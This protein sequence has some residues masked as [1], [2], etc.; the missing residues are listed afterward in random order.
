MDGLAS[1]MRQGFKKNQEEMADMVKNAFQSNQEYMDKRF[2][3]VDKKFDAVDKRFDAMDKRFDQVV[4]EIHKI[5]LN[6]VD[7]V[8]KEDFDKLEDRVVVLEERADL[9]GKKS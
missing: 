4:Q 8:H 9:S 2:D 5:N 1:L 6:A 7:V 3:A